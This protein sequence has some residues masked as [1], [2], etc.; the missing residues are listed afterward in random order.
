[1]AKEKQKLDEA[2]QK[3]MDAETAKSPNDIRQR[4]EALTKRAHPKCYSKS[5]E[6]PH[7]RLTL[8]IG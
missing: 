2:V 7:T 6:N 1:M 3:W 8:G 4:N 5:D